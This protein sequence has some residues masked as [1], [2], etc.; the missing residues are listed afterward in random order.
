MVRPSD[1]I[2]RTGDIAQILQ[3]AVPAVVA[4]VDDGGPDSGGAA[5]TGFVISPDGVIVTNNHVVEGADEDPGAVLRRHD[6]RRRRCSGG[7]P[8]ATSRS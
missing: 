7:M 3:G 4:L 8:R 2:P 1:R 6:A 5:G